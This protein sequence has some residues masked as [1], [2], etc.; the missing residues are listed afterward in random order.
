M[1]QIKIKIYDNTLDFLQ[2]T[3]KNELH[4]KLF[5]QTKKGHDIDEDTADRAKEFIDGGIDES[6]AVE[7]AEEGL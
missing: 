2:N 5:R 3:T 1:K 6:D 7:L 4:K